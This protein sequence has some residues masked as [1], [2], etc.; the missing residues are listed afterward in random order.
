MTLDSL[1]LSLI[2]NQ[3]LFGCSVFEQQWQQSL[4]IVDNF[5]QTSTSLRLKSNDV[6][7]EW[8]EEKVHVYR[9]V[10]GFVS[11]SQLGSDGLIL[12]DRNDRPSAAI[13]LDLSYN[14]KLSELHDSSLSLLKETQTI[15]FPKEY[16][17]F[18][19]WQLRLKCDLSSI[20]SMKTYWKL[21]SVFDHSSSSILNF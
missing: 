13:N 12:E 10:T 17:S 11:Q 4:L 6:I 21:Y 20:D 3:R 1:D 14:A 16:G 9:Q 7:I 18:S 19:Y 2:G 8:S 15:E 5:L